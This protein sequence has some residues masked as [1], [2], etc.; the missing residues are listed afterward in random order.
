MSKECCG[1]CKYH[2]YVDDV[3]FMCDCEA[4]EEYWE[5]T[6]FQDCC[7]CWEEKSEQE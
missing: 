6:M 3:D 1:T 2:S 7:E 5:Y 4:S